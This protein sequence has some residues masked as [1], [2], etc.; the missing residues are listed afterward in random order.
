M[1][2]DGWELEAKDY[3]RKDFIISGHRDRH[4]HVAVLIDD[5]IPKVR[6]LR[7]RGYKKVVAFLVEPRAIKAD[8]YVNVERYMRYFDIVLTYDQYLLEKYPRKCRFVHP[9]GSK[10]LYTPGLHEKSKLCSIIFSANRSTEG[11]ILRHLVFD[12][13]KNYFDGYKGPDTPRAHDKGPWQNDFC[14]SVVIENSRQPHYFTEKLTE[15]MLSGTVPIYW[16]CPTVDQFFDMKGIIVFDSL[17]DL[18][19]ILE[20]LSFEDYKKRLPAIKRNYELAKKYNP[21]ALEVMW[22]WIESYFN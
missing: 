6:K 13:Y 2:V 11:H 4:S 22:P 9:I 17:K 7:R 10:F 21:I 5:W 1:Y 20:N 12:K 8:S 16:G 15:C 18:K 19:P 3:P 14:F